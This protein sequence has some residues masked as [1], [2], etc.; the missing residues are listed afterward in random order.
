VPPS[1]G[2]LSRLRLWS[3]GFYVE[4]INPKH[5]GKPP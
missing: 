1:I 3:I 2:T 5:K 4:M